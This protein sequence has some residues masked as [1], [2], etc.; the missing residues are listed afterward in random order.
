MTTFPTLRIGVLQ[1]LLELK[2][3]TEADDA[4]L[5]SAECP[6]DRETVDAL[7]KI[8]EV[9]TV[10]KE[11]I[12]EVIKE[13][14]PQ[15]GR[16]TVDPKLSEDDQQE[17]EDSARELLTQLKALGE[18][19]TGLDTQTKITIIKAKAVL[20]EQLVKLRERWH[21]VKRVATFQAVV[22]GILDDLVGEDDRQE[23]L[24]RVEPYRE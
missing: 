8:F 14:K 4:L 15:R 20:I 1:A 24:K 7:N 21:N 19:E 13:E 23:F 10:E 11:V 5:S 18:G 16:P 17:V 2:V 3:A 22:I 6:Y 12:K 9:R